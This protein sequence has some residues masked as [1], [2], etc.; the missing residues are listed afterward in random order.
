MSHDHHP[1]ER[2]DSYE[3]FLFPYYYFPELKK[4]SPETDLRRAR[5]VLMLHHPTHSVIFRGGENPLNLSLTPS[6]YR[7]RDQLQP[8]T[9]VK[10][11]RLV[12]VD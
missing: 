12:T 4:R 8:Y 7:N 10:S 2:T 9:P 5:T 3:Q 1:G 6:C 11:K